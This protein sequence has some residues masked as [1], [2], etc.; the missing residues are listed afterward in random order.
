MANSLVTAFEKS[1]IAAGRDL[2]VH[3]SD[4][5][6]RVRPPKGE[7]SKPKGVQCMADNIN[8]AVQEALSVR[9]SN[10]TKTLNEQGYVNRLVPDNSDKKFFDQIVELAYETSGAGGQHSQLAQF[11]GKFDRF[12]RSMVTPNAVFSGHTF[13][14]RPRLCLQDWNIIADRKFGSLRTEDPTS[15]PYAIRC[16]LDPTWAA[17]ANSSICPLFDR[18]NPF[19]VPLTNALKSIS[20]FNDPA[21]VTE[22]TDGGFFSEDQTSVI[23]GDRLART[24]DL[25]CM[26]RDVQGSAI[27]A[28]IDYW[29][30]YMANLQ[31]GSMQQY[32]DAIDANRMD[33]TVSIYRFLMDRTDRYITRWC[34]CTGCYPV[35]P[36]SGVSFNLN[37]G[38]FMVNAATNLNVPFKAN[39]IEYDDPVILREFNMLVRRYARNGNSPFTGTIQAF[40]QSPTNNFSGIP[41]I[42]ATA[43]GYEL[44]WLQRDMNG[45]AVSKQAGKSLEGVIDSDPTVDDNFQSRRLI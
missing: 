7:S 17:L 42:R 15:I 38:E 5:K 14:T 29:C 40:A 28:I 34:K 2:A 19:L 44:L 22:T 39:R 6:W 27:L 1:G 25:N 43:N 41:Y 8:L 24:Y 13:F 30:Q 36:P 4:Q 33:Y 16:Y 26:F 21:L 31:D 45:E 23:G 9:Q 10:D 12:K 37:E 32:A 35:S 20:G 3:G 11:F 18:C